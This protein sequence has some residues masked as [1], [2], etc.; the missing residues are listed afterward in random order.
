MIFF[1]HLATRKIQVAGITPIHIKM[2]SRA[3]V[4]T[5]AVGQL[6]FVRSVAPTGARCAD[7]FARSG[8]PS[9]CRNR[10]VPSASAQ[11]DL[12]GPL[13]VHKELSS[14]IT[15]GFSALP[16]QG[17]QELLQG[18]GGAAERVRARPLGNASG[19]AAAKP[20]LSARIP[21]KTRNFTLHHPSEH[22]RAS[23][24]RDLVRSLPSADA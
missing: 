16:D 4:K 11:N 17:N 9:G 24:V 5:T 19:L 18:H 7:S 21:R 1:M 12:G 20:G 6:P 13:Q 14:C 22:L 23:T 8:Q 2:Q 15:N 10:M 3:S